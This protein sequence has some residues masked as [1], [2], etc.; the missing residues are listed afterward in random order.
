MHGFNVTVFNVAIAT[1]SDTDCRRT[2]VNLQSFVLLPLRSEPMC[3]LQ[4]VRV[5][6]CS[7]I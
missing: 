4:C 6:A 5:C 7:Q 1:L 2:I 3:G